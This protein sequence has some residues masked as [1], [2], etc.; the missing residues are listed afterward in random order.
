MRNTHYALEE[1]SAGE[2]EGVAKRELGGVL[3]LNFSV[4]RAAHLEKAVDVVYELKVQTNSK[5]NVVIADVGIF[6][7]RVVQT[8][9]DVPRSSAVFSANVPP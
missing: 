7:V 8:C 5:A 2:E 6:F 3:V 4:E 1:Q 9:I